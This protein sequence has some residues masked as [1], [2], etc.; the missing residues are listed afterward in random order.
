MEVLDVDEITQPTADPD[1]LLVEIAAASLNPFDIKFVSGKYK[2]SIP[3]DLPITPGGDF[4]GVVKQ[5]GSEVK[6]F[7]IGDEV[8]G[9]ANILSGGSGSLAQL[10]TVKNGRFARK[11]KKLNFVEAAGAVL[12]GVS[13]VQALEEHVELKRE[14]KI[15]IHGGAGGIG[16]MAIQ[17]AKSIGAYVATTVSSVDF[18][19]VKNLGADQVIDY[20]KEDFSKIIKEFDA[21]FDTVGGDVT[22]KSML[23]VK[24]G[25][26]L[27]TMIGQYDESLARKLGVRVIAQKTKT[28]R[29]HLERLAQLLDSS[30][31]QPYID[32]T[33][34]LVDIKTAYAY[35]KSSHLR[36]KVVVQIGE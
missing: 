6:D 12:V 24:S 17:L 4:S 36:G 10:A 13:S 2:D 22:S 26:K 1:Q 21:V 30:K 3:V 35:L 9:T 31:M 16:H 5:V 27:V 32:K 28:N 19:F 14:E 33:F 15:L 7:K 25:G 29:K 34:P 11:P 18:D 20:K 23:V 8:Y